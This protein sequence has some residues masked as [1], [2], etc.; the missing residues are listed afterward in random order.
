MKIIFATGN[1]NKL[2]EAQEIL[3]NNFQIETPE[4]FGITEDIPETSSTIEGN[5]IQKAQYIWN[6]LHLPCFADDTGL[7]VDAL[8]GAPGVYAARYAGEGK[9]P[10]DNIDK[11]LLELNKISNKAY[12]NDRKA[13][14]RCIIAYINETGIQTFEGRCPGF[15]TKERHG[16]G[17]FGYDPIFQPEKYSKCFSELSPE[18]KNKISHRGKAMRQFTKYLLLK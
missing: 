1:K 5:A 14:F 3:G 2:K 4:T 11:M 8:N 16:K 17:G 10:D 18:E 12:A 6:K 13:T 7:E 15:I 9:S